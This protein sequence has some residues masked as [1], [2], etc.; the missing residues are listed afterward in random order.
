M[1]AR[2][3]VAV[4]CYKQEEFLFEC[5]NSLIAQTM[6]N[7]EAFVVDDCSPASTIGQIA[8]SYHDERIC[9][10][11]H[12]ENRGLAAGRNTAIRAGNAPAV[13][14]LDADD[15]LHPEFLFATLNAMER[16]S[17][18]CAFA[19]FQCV[20]LEG[21]VWTFDVRTPDELARRQWVPGSGTIMRRSL[22]ERVGGYCDAVELRAGNE[23][24][25]FWIGAATLGFSAAHVPRPLYFYRR[26][27][28][29]MSKSVLTPIDWKTREF[30]LKRHPKFFS[31]VDRAKVFRTGGLLRSAR[32]ERGAKRRLAA[33]LLTSRAVAIDPKILFSE[34]KSFLRRGYTLVRSLVKGTTTHF[35]HLVERLT[36]ADQSNEVA[37][38][39]L[40]DWEA[41][42][43]IIHQHYGYLSHDYPVLSEIIKKADVRSV[44]EIGCGSGRLVPVYLLHAMDPICLQDI[45]ASALDICRHR[46]FHQKQ[47][48]YFAGD[49]EHMALDANV[50]LIVSTRVLQHI[51]DEDDF[52][53][54]LNYLSKRTHSFYV[55]EATIGD[56]FRDPYI[57][58][59]DYTPIFQGLGF[60]LRDQG[61]VESE[62]GGRQSWKLYAS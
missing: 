21:Q 14:C 42:A 18:D 22:W 4:P 49:L 53:R 50:D 26:H 57:K 23:D 33:L 17:V 37:D 8:A 11:R 54:K 30:I 27:A 10:M 29:S 2:V 5:L 51:L 1:N 61:E 3:T 20:G 46:F 15:F 58:G 28:I 25:D 39:A 38:D 52:R 43:P 62:G 35:R 9:C 12:R 34:T 16:D 36:A 13:L 55:N 19:D 45:A 31:T 7:W 47:I 56:N 40:R 48:R 44:L 59:R 24:W 60:H 6:T 32:A 41:L